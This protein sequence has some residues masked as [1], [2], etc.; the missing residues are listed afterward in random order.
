MVDDVCDR[1][2]YE[3]AIS[4]CVRF[5]KRHALKHFIYYMNGH[6][7]RRLFSLPKISSSNCK[8]ILKW[9]CKITCVCNLTCS[10]WKNMT[11]WIWKNYSKQT[12]KRIYKIVRKSGLFSIYREVKEIKVILLLLYNIELSYSLYIQPISH[13]LV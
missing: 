5:T 8:K 9:M 10:F 3:R 7:C 12:Y 13:F 2:N 4:S 11:I 1:R 6:R